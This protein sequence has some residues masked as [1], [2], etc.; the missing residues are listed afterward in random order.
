MGICILPD[1]KDAAVRYARVGPGDVL[2]LPAFGVTVT[3]MAY[4]ATKGCVL[5]DTTCGS[6]LNVWK[7][8]NRCARDGFTVLIHGK[9]YHEETRATASQTL[10]HANAHYLCVRDVRETAVVCGYLRGEV[11]AEALLER[12]GDASSPGFTPAR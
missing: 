3:E 11:T 6:V 2:I 9:H 10:G 4:L 1:S 5:V 12:F 8:V 7:K